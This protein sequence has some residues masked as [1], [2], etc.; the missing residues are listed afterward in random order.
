MAK[1][2]KGAMLHSSNAATHSN[3]VHALMHCLLPSNNTW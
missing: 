1:M 2:T 3:H